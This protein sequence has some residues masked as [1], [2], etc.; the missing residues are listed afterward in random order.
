MEVAIATGFPFPSQTSRSRRNILGQRPVMH[1][2]EM[3]GKGRL[4]RP[5][6][7]VPDD[8]LGFKVRLWEA[9][10]ARSPRANSESSFSL[11]L[12]RSSIP[13]T[14]RRPTDLEKIPSC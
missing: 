12:R 8:W 5:V 13:Q 3:R 11:C 1:E 2:V 7:Y 6:I 10:S 4:R 9:Y 14:T